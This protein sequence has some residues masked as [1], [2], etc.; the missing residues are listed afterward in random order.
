VHAASGGKNEK[1][2]VLAAAIMRGV[3]MR[4]SGKWVSLI[5][6]F[7]CAL[8]YASPSLTTPFALLSCYS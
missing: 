8:M 1:A 4:P 5:L 7:E 6:R 3:T 2:A